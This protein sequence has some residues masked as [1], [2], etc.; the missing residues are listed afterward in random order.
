[1]QKSC[2][3]RNKP[4][5]FCY[6]SAGFPPPLLGAGHS[7]WEGFLS[8]S[9]NRTQGACEEKALDL[10]RQE[11]GSVAPGARGGCSGC[12]RESLRKRRARGCGRT[13]AAALP[14]APGPSACFGASPWGCTFLGCNLLPFLSRVLIFALPGEVGRDSR[15]AKATWGFIAGQNPGLVSHRLCGLCQEANARRK[16]RFSTFHYKQMSVRSRVWFRKHPATIRTTIIS[17]GLKKL[18]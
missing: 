14:R 2:L 9:K 3:W 15:S 17:R 6:C 4:E 7:W 13:A 5:C 8:V 1:M 10:E 18:C 12:V 11:G 16:S